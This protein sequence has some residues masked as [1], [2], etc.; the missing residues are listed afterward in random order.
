MAEQNVAGNETK[1]F[2]PLSDKEPNSMTVM[3]VLAVLLH[4]KGGIGATEQVVMDESHAGN[5]AVGVL[6]EL[7]RTGY[8]RSFINQEGTAGPYARRYRLV[9]GIGVELNISKP[10]KPA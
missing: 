2:L 6:G 5:K 7:E 1:V 4:H 9:D 10:S 3:L 8:V